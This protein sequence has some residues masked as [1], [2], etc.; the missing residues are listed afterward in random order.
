MAQNSLK[1]QLAGEALIAELQAS[2]SLC[3]KSAELIAKR[4]FT[5]EDA[6]S[7][8][9]QTEFR[10]FSE[11]S[12][13]DD[14]Q[15]AQ[16]LVLESKQLGVFC[17]YDADG[18]LSSETIRCFLDEIG[19]KYQ[20]HIPE[21]KESYG[22]NRAAL[23]RFQAQGV[24][25]LFTADCGSSDIEE[26][27]YAKTLGMKVIITDHHK[28]AERPPADAFLNSVDTEFASLCGCSVAG[29]TLRGLSEKAFTT[30]KAF[31]SVATIADIV[32]LYQES[33]Q[34]V[35][36]FLDCPTLPGI[37]APA[38][39]SVSEF[40]INSIAFQVVPKI[41]ALSRMGKARLVFK[42]RQMAVYDAAKKMKLINESRKRQQLELFEHL[43]DF[44][45]TSSEVIVACVP[46]EYKDAHGFF[47]LV[48]SRITQTYKKPSL[49]GQMVN[50]RF[51]GSGRSVSW[52]NLHNL[53]SYAA[54]DYDVEFGG[55]SVALGFSAADVSDFA[56]A[57]NS[58][59]AK[60]RE[61]LVETIP[62]EVDFEMSVNELIQLEPVYSELSPFGSGF[63]AIKVRVNDL[64]IDKYERTGF[65]SKVT[66]GNSIIYAIPGIQDE[67]KEA[68]TRVKTVDLVISGVENDK[69]KYLVEAFDAPGFIPTKKPKTK[70]RR[71]WSKSSTP[72]ALTRL[73]QRL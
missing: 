25:T 56:V 5:L 42:L 58:Q 23:R 62:D 53:L 28:Y 4:N 31:M 34:L 30:A 64:H 47:G 49:V 73:A 8:L 40:D 69:L 45:D 24:D 60:H 17:D 6:A 3:R 13:R 36:G 61:E 1:T 37:L 26:I 21:R 71:I 41:N 16:Q 63:P 66:R 38:F 27:L 44:I 51:K 32:P 22:L 72:K 10:K 48:A 12:L 7:L 59:F 20:M 55:H 11:T 18:I 57:V 68:G 2:F 29:M 46:E 50:N 33:R 19:S 15:R 65:F 52:I 9:F 35:Q 67:L 70:K 54:E 39:D 43:D 14:T